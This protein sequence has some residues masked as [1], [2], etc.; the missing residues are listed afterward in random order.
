MYFNVHLINYGVPYTNFNHIQQMQL[1]A[2]GE[3]GKM[4]FARALPPHSSSF[5]LRWLA[6]IIIAY[7]C[8]CCRH[9]TSTQAPTHSC[10]PTTLTVAAF[11]P[12]PT[13]AVPHIFQAFWFLALIYFLMMITVLSLI[14]CSLLLL[15]LY[16]FFI[17]CCFSYSCLFLN[18][19]IA[20]LVLFVLFLLLM[21]MMMREWILSI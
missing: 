12:P 5:K 9:Y 8:S 20:F 4:H 3:C 10:T 6:P 21:V 7:H 15:I 13:I 18:L 19:I 14:F 1:I 11:R 2:F 16:L 17:D